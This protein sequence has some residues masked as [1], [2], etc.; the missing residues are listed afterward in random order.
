[1]LLVNMWLKNSVR[2]LNEISFSVLHGRNFL[3]HPEYIH[4]MSNI[5]NEN[6]LV[7]RWQFQKTYF[8]FLIFPHEQSLSPPLPMYYLCFMVFLIVDY[9]TL[10]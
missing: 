6:I 4:G 5:I 1:M 9:E 8:K 10:S 3:D 7:D 2:W